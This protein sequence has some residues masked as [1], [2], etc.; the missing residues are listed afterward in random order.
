[1]KPQIHCPQEVGDSGASYSCPKGSL[2]DGELPF[3][4]VQ[5]Y[6]HFNDFAL[7]L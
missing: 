5:L 6:K 3:Y 1:M 7:K 2:R 4:I